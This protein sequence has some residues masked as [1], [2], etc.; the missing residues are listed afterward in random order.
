[1]LL[2]TGSREKFEKLERR[3]LKV[4]NE[5]KVLEARLDVQNKPKDTTGDQ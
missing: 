4:E 2:G 3:L 1:M 5:K